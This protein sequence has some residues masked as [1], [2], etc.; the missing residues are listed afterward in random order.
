MNHRPVV[1]LVCDTIY[2][3]SHGGRELR[4]QQLL[5][6]LAQYA[7]VHVYTMHWWDGPTTRTND[8]ITYHAISRLLPLYKKDRRSVAQGIRFGLASLRLLSQRFDVLEADHIPYFQVFALRFVATVKRKS[9]LVTWHE[10][11]SQSSWRNYI[12]WA[13]WAAWSMEWLAMRLP[14]HIIAASPQ[15]A[16]RLQAALGDRKLITVVPNGIDLDT[17]RSTY[18]DA[19]SVEITAVGRLISHK[20]VDLLLHVI[21]LLHE[22]GMPVR[23]RIVGD[24]PEREALKERVCVLGLANV[25]EFR[26]DVREQKELYALI[27]ATKVFVS[28]F[29]SRRLWHSSSRSYRL[30]SPGA[31]YVCPRQFGAT[32]RRQVFPGHGL[33]TDTGCCGWCSTGPARHGE[34]A[35]SWQVSSRRLGGQLRL[36]S[37]SG[38]SSGRVFAVNVPRANPYRPSLGLYPVDYSA[39]AEITSLTDARLRA[40]PAVSCVPWVMK[41]CDKPR[42]SLYSAQYGDSRTSSGR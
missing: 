1:A 14:D 21:A 8:G 16:E 36:E 41:I 31:D 42:R 9:F 33:R 10:V 39:A 18:P 30:R 24:G 19:E 27:K 20:R 28:L 7:E 12:G 22:R 3:Y 17:I 4:Y 29:N 23:C 26:H 38:A 37:Y 2:P 11:W 34:G 15:T 25:V 6:W 32:S 35:S 13:G 40:D 5:P